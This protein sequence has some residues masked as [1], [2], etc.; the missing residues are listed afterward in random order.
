MARLLIHGT[1]HGK[2]TSRRLPESKILIV[3]KGGGSGYIFSVILIADFQGLEDIFSGLTF[4]GEVLDVGIYGGDRSDGGSGGYR[5]EGYFC[6]SDLLGMA[7]SFGFS[8]SLGGPAFICA[9]SFLV[10]SET[11]SFPHTSSTISWRELLQ[12]DGIHIHGI[13]VS[14]GVQVGGEGGE[15]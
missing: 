10:T 13:G 7:A 9:V 6:V 5:G 3:R 1:S 4:G 14:G 2:K 11:E 8:L 15:G 12:A